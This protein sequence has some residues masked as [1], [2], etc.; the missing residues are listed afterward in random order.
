MSVKES[1]LED[2][3]DFKKVKIKVFNEYYEQWENLKRFLL[4]YNLY[5]YHRQK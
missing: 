5:I 1:D 4:K 3:K 2:K